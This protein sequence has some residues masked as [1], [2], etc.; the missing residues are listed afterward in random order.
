MVGYIEMNKVKRKKMSSK[1]I[2]ETTYDEVIIIMINKV[3]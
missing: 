1:K 2:N 3:R